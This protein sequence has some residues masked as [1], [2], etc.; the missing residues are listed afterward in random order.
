MPVTLWHIFDSELSSNHILNRTFKRKTKFCYEYF[1]F[2]PIPNPTY[3]CQKPD[4]GAD[5]D[6]DTI[7]NVL[8]TV[9]RENETSWKL[10][11][12]T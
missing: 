8:Q 4:V 7:R 6:S 3:E 2:W 10:E 11:V 1:S 9:F 12:D 5:P